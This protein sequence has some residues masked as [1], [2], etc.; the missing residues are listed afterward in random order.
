MNWI[1][2]LII[3]LGLSS[4]ALAGSA[5]DPKAHCGYESGQW[6]PETE[7]CNVNGEELFCRKTDRDKSETSGGNESNQAAE[8]LTE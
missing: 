4:T 8:T 3:S 1:V 2:K 6:D 5:R 7:C